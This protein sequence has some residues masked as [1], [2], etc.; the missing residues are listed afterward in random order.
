M[1]NRPTAFVPA[2]VI[3]IVAL[4]LGGVPWN[5]TG[6]SSPLPTAPA[7]Q[8][9]VPALGP[10]LTTVTLVPSAG[11]VSSS[12]NLTAAGFPPGPL[13]LTW[14]GT[15][16]AC[17]PNATVSANASGTATCDF[18]V[19]ILP[20]GTYNVTATE[21]NRTATAPFDIVA[22]TLSASPGN[23]SVGALVLMTGAGFVPNATILAHLGTT[24]IPGCPGGGSLVA[25]STGTLACGMSVP[26][27]A[28]GT[29]PLTAN[30]SVNQAAVSFTI[31]PASIAL[32][33]GSG[34]VGTAVSVQGQGF[35]PGTNVTVTFG[36]LAVGCR[37]G[38]PAVNSTGAFRC[39]IVVPTLTAGPYLI[40]ANDSWNAASAPFRV[41][42]PTLAVTP[43]T[44]SVG[45]SVLATGAG[46]A[47]SARLTLT[48]GGVAVTCGAVGPTSNASGDLHCQFRVPA[49]PAGNETLAANDSVNRATTVFTV[50]APRLSIAP[51]S[52]YVGSTATLEGQGFAPQVAATVDFSGSAISCTSGSRVANASGSFR[53]GFTVPTSL[54]AGT[55]AV[56]ATDGINT[57]T[58]NYTIGPPTLLLGSG[59]G[60]VGSVL[61]VSG[62]GYVP[63]ASLSVEFAG[64]PV[65]CGPGSTRANASGG[66]RCSLSVPT[67]PH[68]SYG[69]TVSDGTNSAAASYTVTPSVTLTPSQGYNG[70]RLTI[71]GAGFDASA[72]EVNV[73]WDGA[74]ALCT[75]YTSSIGTFQCGGPTL[76]PPL[77]TPSNATA[78]P[79]V[80]VAS[81]GAGRVSATANFTVDSLLVAAPASAAAGTV[82]HFEGT[83][84]DPQA[85]FSLELNGVAVACGGSRTDSNGSFDCPYT[86][87]AAT[88]G[89]TYPLNVTEGAL[90]NS[91]WFT[92]EATLR[93]SPSTGTEGTVVSLSGSNFAALTS[94]A[95]CLQ[96]APLA[97]PAG[98]P[99]FSTD[100][101]GGVPAGVSLAIPG[102]SP[103]GTYFVDVSN[104]SSVVSATLEV[105]SASLGAYPTSGSVGS[106]VAIQGTGF[107]PGTIYVYCMLKVPA[108]CPAGV[109]TEFRANAT[110][111]IPAGVGVVVPFLPGGSSAIDVSIGSVLAASAAFTILANL[112]GVPRSADVGTSVVVEGTGFD[113]NQSVAGGFSGGPA[114]S[115]EGSAL[116][117]NATGAFLC[118][119]TVPPVPGGSHELVFTEGTHRVGR[120]VEVLPAIAFAPSASPA[121]RPI[122][123]TGTGF[124]AN[125]TV[126][127]RW[128]GNAIGCL[129][130]GAATNATGGF[131][132]IFL[133][134]PTAQPGG[135]TV[136]AYAGSYAVKFTFPVLVIPAISI[137]E[138]TGGT[139]GPVGTAVKVTG[140][141]FAPSTAVSLTFGSGTPIPS[142]LAPSPSASPASNSTGAMTCYFDVP[143]A[144]A[145]P[146][147]ISAF[148]NLSGTRVWANATFTVIPEISLLPT[149]G[150]AGALVT[151]IGTGFVPSDHTSNYTVVWGT[152]TTLCNGTTD[153][154]GNLTCRFVVPLGKAGTYPIWVNDLP[155]PPNSGNF[156]VVPA[157]HGIPRWAIYAG[158]VVGGVLVI[159]LLALLVRR[160]RQVAGAAQLAPPPGSRGDPPGDSFSPPERLA[161]PVGAE[162][163]ASFPPAPA[164]PPADISDGTEG[165][166]G[167]LARVT[168]LRQSLEELRAAKDRSAPGGPE[169]GPAPPATRRAADSRT[170]RRIPPP[171]KPS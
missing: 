66:F 130:G 8:G 16:L 113:A 164:P 141:G 104:T 168:E 102:G 51:N 149:S 13:N 52:G 69:V 117:T 1:R 83:G 10:N 111:A 87:S 156:T 47:P 4:V 43:A 146:H 97:C 35:G 162:G 60:T 157:T 169:A 3:L 17:G 89:G 79:H 143:A 59:A 58:A 28:R 76:I 24:S 108:A 5:L 116:R 150:R 12:I 92:V 15:Y 80:V 145:G 93:T 75:T 53:C 171:P 99:S 73:T 11:W 128:D 132:C 25:S 81:E 125:A 151:L 19:P 7:S 139:Q 22:P 21:G 161:S 29:Y 138:V 2:S 68:G 30:D 62:I 42:A 148:Q 122:T 36:G 72:T 118:R 70:T 39:G 135:H 112:S 137:G 20:V 110:G 96:P 88:P 105:T 56:N 48:L 85:P 77:L 50:G 127:M 64:T 124:S 18:S 103:P 95:F 133:V 74:V 55:Y 166:D 40:A 65:S 126:T 129:L 160:S 144:G 6:T 98:S 86:V 142:C 136:E 153:T 78:G 155:L 54:A 109:G 147:T 49:V 67:L 115:C 152:S 119:W 37:S 23:A 121:G 107:D 159:A 167:L 91:T 134:P 26:A 165:Y 123:V 100:S 120:S 106:S 34:P 140:A 41:D 71:L 9:P 46:Y 38:S 101:T 90:T 131:T 27:M 44:G 57:A 84:F 82:V 163:A 158:L 61:Q 170:A 114:P 94:Y 63:L 32:S 154:F 31:D 14:A 33:T 45:T